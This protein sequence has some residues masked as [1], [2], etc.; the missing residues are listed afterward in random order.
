MLP[1]TRTKAVHGIY[2]VETRRFRP[3]AYTPNL[4]SERLRGPTCLEAA[5]LRQC[6]RIARVDEGRSTTLVGCVT[7]QQRSIKNSSGRE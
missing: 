5:G 4:S 6:A 7:A 3:R 1:V 2:L